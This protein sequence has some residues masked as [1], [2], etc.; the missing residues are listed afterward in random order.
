MEASG[1]VE[2]GTHELEQLRPKAPHKASAPIIYD[3][4]KQAP[5]P[6]H[7]LEQ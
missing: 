5:M 7:M 6:H 1:E 4:S 2:L 3:G